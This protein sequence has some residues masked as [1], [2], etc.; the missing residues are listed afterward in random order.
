[1]NNFDNKI[2][3]FLGLNSVKKNVKNAS[4]RNQTKWKNMS[5]IKKNIHRM[6]YKDTDKDN[7][8]D[9][10]DCQPLNIFK[11][12]KI[13]KSKLITLYHG[14]RK[15]NLDN[16]K[17]KG[18]LPKKGNPQQS[19][20]MT[21]EIGLAKG[22][23]IIGGEG[24][25]DEAGSIKYEPS[26]L[27]I[28]IPKKYLQG[29]FEEHLNIIEPEKELQGKAFFR[30]GEFISN[31]NISPDKFKALS[32]KEIKKI[33]LRQNKKFY[34]YEIDK[35]HRENK[36]KI[37]KPSFEELVQYIKEGKDDDWLFFDS[38]ASTKEVNEAKLYVIR[39]ALNN[40]W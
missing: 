37:Q 14:T 24:Y 35:Y 38:G 7:V 28:T 20:F 33:D 30:S 34:D 29:D 23:G 13:Q 21:G 5:S 18:L 9:K 32:E 39:N 17:K 11:Q 27:K 26:V 40:I 22:Y 6:L 4:I 15:E 10:W 2:K 16:I 12:E 1:M 3:R 8:P 25:N 36:E 19:I 31:K